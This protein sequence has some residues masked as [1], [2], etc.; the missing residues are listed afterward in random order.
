[1]TTVGHTLAG[2][3]IAVLTLPRKQMYRWYVLTGLCFVFFANVPDLPLPGWGHNLYYVSHSVFVTLLLAILLAL[4]LL[5]PTF[6]V[7]VAG[8]VV[9]AW[10]AAWLSHMVLDSMY[11]HGRGIAIF[12]PFS[13]AHL[14]MPVPW[15]ETLNMPVRSAH[16][17]R[18]FAIE[19]MVYGLIFVLCVGLRRT[20]SRRRY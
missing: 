7:V 3:S 16:N 10:S 11:A 6:R 14:A 15:F 17:L 19:A 1:V 18:V 20:W 12:W 9:A 13:G 8:R 2:L 4:L 5:W